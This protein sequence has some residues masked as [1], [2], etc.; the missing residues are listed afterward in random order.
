M[1]VSCGVAAFPDDAKNPTE[2]LA[3][4]D[5]ALYVAKERG[6]DRAGQLLV[7]RARAAGHPW[8]RRPPAELESLTQLK[9]LGALADQAQPAERRQQIGETIVA[10][11]R[12]MIDYH[13][14]RVYLLD[15][16]QPHAGAGRL[17]RHLTQ[18]YAGRDVRRAALRRWGR[19]SPAPRPLRGQTLN[20][21]DAQ[22]CEFAEDIEGSADIEESILAVPMRYERRTIGVIVLSK[23]GLDQFSQLAVRL[24]ELLAAQAAV[25]F[26][27]ARLLEAE[28][29]SAAVSNAL[30]EI[31]TMAATDPSVSA[32]A[33]HLAHVARSLTG[34]RAAAVVVPADPASGCSRVLAS[35]G[36]AAVRAIATAAV[37]AGFPRRDEVELVDV[38]NLPGP[39]AEASTLPA[40]TAVVPVNGALL[41]VVCDSF[42]E[43]AQAVLA[44][45][46][47]QGGLALRSAALLAGRAIA[48]VAS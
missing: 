33:A 45:V 25:A 9:L 43:R 5:A 14:A 7:G 42:S 29:R 15:D 39:A 34:S 28:R 1:T 30:L 21:G 18:E 6:K 19:A 26:E 24:L 37:R 3:A 38:A 48:D 11:L 40:V 16:D 46:A 10:E 23:L 31:A 13:N 8:R 36:D 47:G 12:T 2:L 27:N 35:T 4:A 17:R 22:H 20:I 41:V 44:A 32:V